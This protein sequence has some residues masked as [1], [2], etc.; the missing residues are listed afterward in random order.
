MVT[1]TAGLAGILYILI[2]QYPKKEKKWKGWLGKLAAGFL[3]VQ[4]GLGIG[5]GGLGEFL[6]VSGAMA[7]ETVK[8][9][10]F[11]VSGILQ[12]LV[13]IL[14][15][16]LLFVHRYERS[17]KEEKKLLFL[18]LATGA[19]LCVIPWILRVLAAGVVLQSMQVVW[20]AFY[21]IL[22]IVYFGERLR[23]GTEHA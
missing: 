3:A 2:K 9:F 6:Y 15:L 20:E 14:F 18:A 23:E 12:S 19:V 4:L 7:Y 13:R 21:L 17:L 10:L 1:G 16:Y 8:P 11:I 5:L 22:F